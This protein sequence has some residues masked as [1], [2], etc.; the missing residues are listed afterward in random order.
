MLYLEDEDGGTRKDAALCCCKLVSNSFSGISCT[1]FSSSRINR[2][3]GRRRRLVEE[4]LLLVTFLHFPN[5]FDL[6]SDRLGC[7]CTS[8]ASSQ[9]G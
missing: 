9:K 8:M 1:Q 3:G 4:V 7:I 2:T 6:E 5:E